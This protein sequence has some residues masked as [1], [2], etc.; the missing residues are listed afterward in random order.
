[1]TGGY[2]VFFLACYA[3]IS[4]VSTREARTKRMAFLD[5][6]FPA[7]FFTGTHFLSDFYAIIPLPIADASAREAGLST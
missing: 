2:V 6:L 1:M 3:Y 5:G 7:G 4:D